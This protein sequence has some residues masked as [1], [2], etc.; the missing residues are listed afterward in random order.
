MNRTRI[1]LVLAACLAAA[2]CTTTSNLHPQELNRL[3]GFDARFA[4]QRDINT[5]DGGPVRF[6]RD[7][8]LRLDLPTEQVD[9]QFDYIQVHEGVF[10]GRTSSGHEIQA[11]LADIR[12]AAVTEPS[13]GKSVAWLFSLLGAFAV[14]TFLATAA[15]PHAVPGRP[16]RIGARMVAAATTVG[17]DWR[18][19]GV[20]PDLES[21]PAA[22]RAALASAWTDGAR[23]EHASVAAFSRLSLTLMAVGAPARLVEAAHCAALQ[24]IEHARLAFTIAGA[25][26]GQPLAPRPLTELAAAP[27]I[28]GSSLAELASESLIDG[29]LNE[30]LSAAVA[31]EGARQAQDP[32]IA[33]ALEIIARDEASHAALAWDVVDWCLAQG[34]GALVAGALRRLRATPL[35]GAAWRAG[36][37][38]EAEL[39]RHGWPS[40]NRRRELSERVHADAVAR[41][42]VMARERSRTTSCAASES[43]GLRVPF[44]AVLPGPDASDSA[45]LR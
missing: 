19:S 34:N 2:A 35:L 31:A 15:T 21:V 45:L 16:L 4:A 40:A 10:A 39:E 41:L 1:N 36:A 27:A 12:A 14:V 43:G 13:P 28:T 38:I 30:G 26:A 3:D 8:R 17:A 22:V 24:E 7:T 5:L 11:P 33:T 25:Y 37:A 44:V 20:A 6:N 18:R 29:C 9:G 32:A 42:E 23:A